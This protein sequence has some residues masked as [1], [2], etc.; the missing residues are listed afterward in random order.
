M[1]ASSDFALSGVLM[2]GAT[3]GVSLILSSYFGHVEGLEVYTAY[4]SD[5]P[6]WLNPQNWW[7]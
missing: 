3:L 6:A 1:G 5:P 4:R 2:T 7:P